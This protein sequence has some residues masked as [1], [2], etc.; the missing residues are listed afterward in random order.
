MDAV[1]RT[2][3]RCYSPSLAVSALRHSD[4]HASTF[5]AAGR[6]HVYCTLLGKQFNRSDGLTQ[7][8][9]MYDQEGSV[10]HAR[11]VHALDSD[12]STLDVAAFRR[13]R[14][15]IWFGL[16]SHMCVSK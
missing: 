7:F 2:V 12:R 14:V 15:Y 13:L 8:K 3:S 4:A 10:R 16:T 9:A 6:A 1:G 5:Y 11:E